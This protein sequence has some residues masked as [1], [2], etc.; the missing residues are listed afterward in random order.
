MTKDEEEQ[1][2]KRVA[3]LSEF[4]KDQELRDLNR[5]ILKL[6]MLRGINTGE[7]YT[8]RGRYKM[9]A[10]EYG[11][12]MMVWYAACWAGSAAVVY[13]LAEVGGLDAMAVLAK[14][15]TY[16]GLGMADRVDPS[17]GKLGIVLI[18]NE[19][20]EPIRLPIVVLTVKPVVD[21]LFPPKV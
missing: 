6:T 4:K 20:L 15:D 17:L 8:I 10:S 5:K 21:R 13:T 11:L 18:L 1:E 9:L 14:A 16:T 3:G 2:K 12:P 19:L 7:L